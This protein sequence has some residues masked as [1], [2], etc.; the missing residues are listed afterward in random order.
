VTKLKADL[1]A[2][3]GL[4]QIATAQ[5]VSSAQLHTIVTNAIQNALNKAVSAGDITQAQET[6][7]MQFLNNHPHLLDHLLDRHSG[8]SKATKTTTNQ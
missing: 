4:N 8:K 1:Q 2:G 7:F 6:T 5:K 3:Q